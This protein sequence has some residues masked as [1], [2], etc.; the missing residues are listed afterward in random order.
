MVITAPSGLAPVYFIIDHPVLWPLPAAHGRQEA[1]FQH[2]RINP[3]GF[4]VRLTNRCLH[5]DLPRVVRQ[6][7]NIPPPINST[8][9]INPAQVAGG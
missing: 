7:A 2:W 3:F 5:C 4:D 6:I 8:I 9:P 1:G